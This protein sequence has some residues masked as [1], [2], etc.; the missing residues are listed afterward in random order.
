MS[1]A[2]RRKRSRFTL[3]RNIIKGT[4]LGSL[5]LSAAC[6]VDA[7]VIEPHW[8]EL[9]ELE[10]PLADLPEAF[11]GKRLVHISD[12]HCSRVVK[13]DYLLRCVERI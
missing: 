13:K 1:Q 9:A 3:R 11:I 7:I 12:L 2:A 6:A 5:G 4:L 8:V 10:L